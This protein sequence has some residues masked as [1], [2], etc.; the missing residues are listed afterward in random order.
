MSFVVLCGVTRYF[1]EILVV[2]QDLVGTWVPSVKLTLRMRR[3]LLL[4]VP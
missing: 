3:K 1:K 4:L 2:V